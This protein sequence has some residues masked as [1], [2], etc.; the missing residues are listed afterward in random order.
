MSVSKL[1]EYYQSAQFLPTH[2]G[3]DEAAP[4]LRYAESRREFYQS[5]LHIPARFFADADVLEIG[6]DTGENAAVFAAW[7]ANLTLV[8]PNRA[9]WPHIEKYFSR[10]GL[11]DRL[12]GMNDAD[13][14]SYSTDRRFDLVNAEGFIYTIQPI[15]RWVRRLPLFLKPGGF[16]C[17][18]YY[19]RAGGFLELVLKVI[20]AA[21]VRSAGGEPV[22]VARRFFQTKWDAIPHTRPFASWVMDVLENP[23]VRLRTFIDAA[24]L[25]RQM[26]EQGMELYSSWPR[27]R[28]ELVIRWHKTPTTRE[29]RLSE[30]LEH[31]ARTTL[32]P[33][34]GQTILM[35]GA[36]DAVADTGRQVERL[37]VLVDGM[38]DHADPAA[39]DEAGD[40]LAALA[41]L[42]ELQAVFVPGV[43]S[44]ESVQASV[45]TCRRILALVAAGRMDELERLC[46]TDQA[47]IRSWG[48]PHHYAVFCNAH[49]A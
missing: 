23:F 19:E 49:G 9:A 7:G 37:L 41:A 40:I 34:F 12:A 44:R 8:E 6:P 30:N 32:G 42:M 29:G 36:S 35:T 43:A 25:C 15:S 33:M 48:L 39:A 45:A 1:Y 5:K 22:E 20:Q 14:E 46:N 28:D 10:F 13:F 3:F 47:F 18:S 38:I 27:Y 11:A 26:A 16:C 17:V 24:D 21:A 2:A 31:I 4:F